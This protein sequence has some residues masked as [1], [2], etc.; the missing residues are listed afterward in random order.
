MFYSIDELVINT[1]N[2]VVPVCKMTVYSNRHLYAITLFERFLCKWEGELAVSLLF[3]GS[4][5]KTLDKVGE[6]KSY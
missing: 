5:T 3:L 4:R 6:M 1:M 2:L